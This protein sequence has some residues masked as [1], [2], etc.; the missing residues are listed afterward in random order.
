[1][2]EDRHCPQPPDYR[3]DW[4]A[5]ENALPW[6]EEMAACPQDPVWHAEGDVWTHT[7]MVCEQLVQ[8]ADWRRLPRFERDALFLAALLHDCA[9]PATTIE[10][11]GRI[12]APRHSIKGAYLAR[13]LLLSSW[14]PTETVDDV[15]FRELVCSL[16]RSHGAPLHSLEHRDGA[17]RATLMSWRGR[18]DLVSTLAEADIRGRVSADRTEQL[19]RIELFREFC[20]ELQCYDQPR[21][22]VDAHTRVAYCEGR[23]H[24]PSVAAFDDTVCEV[25]MMAGLPASGKSHWVEQNS[26]GAVVVSLDRLRRELAVDP[27]GEQGA[28]INRAKQ[29]ARELLAKRRSFFWNATNVNRPVRKQLIQLFRSY[30]ARVR[31]V[32]VEA[33]WRCIEARNSARSHPVPAAVIEQMLEK[34]EPPDLTEAHEVEIVVT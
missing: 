12:R 19:E 11:S 28:V 9:K 24:P 34:L 32:Y 30:R 3:I 29:T 33:G 6:V 18:C 27:G 20:R 2:R 14:T 13:R 25:V 23:E 8:I 5:I 10:D 22:C 7:K 15:R 17:R 26:A 31:I 16:V 1:M 4:P 21:P